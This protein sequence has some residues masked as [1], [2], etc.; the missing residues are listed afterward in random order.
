[1][2]SEDISTK[3]WI[4]IFKIT[5]LHEITFVITWVLNDL[6]YNTPNR[7]LYCIFAV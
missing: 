3:I 7:E 4:G 5:S 1:M 6:Q 2:L